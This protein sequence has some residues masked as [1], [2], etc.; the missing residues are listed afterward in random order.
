MSPARTRRRKKV[1]TAIETEGSKAIAV[2]A[3]V[4]KEAEVQGMFKTMFDAF[5]TIDI[6]V[7]K[8]SYADG[9]PGPGAGAAPYPVNSIGPGA[10]RTPINTQAWETPA[11][12]DDLMRLIP[13]KR[14]GEPA[15]IAQVAVFLASDLAD[16]VTGQTIF[17]DGG[18][19]CYPEFATGG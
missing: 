16:Y 18:M 10:I 8:P 17:V 19:T 13:Y 9:D 15:D 11:A 5:G 12:Y 7:A 1:V 4:S 14:I 2:K 3:D 6:L